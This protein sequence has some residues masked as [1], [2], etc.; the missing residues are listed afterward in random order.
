MVLTC[1]TA[2]SDPSMKSNRITIHEH[3]HVLYRQLDE[4]PIRYLQPGSGK[5]QTRY[6]WTSNFPG[7]TVFYHWHNGRSTAGM[8]GLFEPPQAR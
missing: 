6:L 2:A 4:T 8:T 7:A 5:A 1:A 3:W